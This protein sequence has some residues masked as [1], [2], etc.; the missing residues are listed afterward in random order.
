[1]LVRIADR[2]LLFFWLPWFNDAFFTKNTVKFKWKTTIKWIPN[3]DFIGQSLVI[4]IASI[5]QYPPIAWREIRT[6]WE[7]F[8]KFPITWAKQPRLLQSED[9]IGSCSV[10][11]DRSHTNTIHPESLIDF[12]IWGMITYKTYIIVLWDLKSII[13]DQK[14]L[15]NNP[16][17]TLFQSI[18]L[19]AHQD[20][21][22][23]QHNYPTR[24]WPRHG[25][26]LLQY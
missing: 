16:Y 3:I 15:L 4:G 5:D 17:H 2:F 9:A 7:T 24:Q 22:T 1:M 26:S 19:P 18:D 23:N 14:L 12:F 10:L 20:S 21:H 13:H 25:S 6:G 8:N 11:L